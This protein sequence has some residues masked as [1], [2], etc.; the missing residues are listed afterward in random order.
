M[1][2]SLFFELILSYWKWYYIL[3]IIVC[4]CYLCLDK[5]KIVL[6]FEKFGIDYFFWRKCSVECM[7]WKGNSIM[8]IDVN[9]GDLFCVIFMCICSKKY[10]LIFNKNIVFFE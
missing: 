7:M 2:I 3:K 5:N 1:I 4:I 6:F 9:N 10:I 8:G